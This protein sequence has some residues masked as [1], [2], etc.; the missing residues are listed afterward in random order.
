[1]GLN[2]NSMITHRYATKP[3]G[4][5]VQNRTIG[6]L[7]AGILIATQAHF[8]SSGATWFVTSLGDAGPG[9]L[10][11]RV[12]SASDGDWIKFSVIG[13]IQLES[14]IEV[15]HRIGIAGPSAK[16]LTIDGQNFD[17]NLFLVSYDGKVGG[18]P[19]E[20]KTPTFRGM[21]LINAGDH[22]IANGYEFGRV[23]IERC[24]FESN[25][26]A[27]FATTVEIWNSY[28]GGNDYGTFS[29]GDMQMV[30]CTVSGNLKRA[31]SAGADAM[32]LNSTIVNNA[33]NAVVGAGGGVSA[34]AKNLHLYN[35]IIAGN[36]EYDLE[37]NMPE[38]LVSSGNL[39]SSISPMDAED[40]LDPTDTLGL[41]LAQ[42][43]LAPLAFNGGGTKNHRPNPGSPAI[44][45][46]VNGVLPSS[47]QRGYARVVGA[48]VDVGAVEFGSHFNGFKTKLVANS[49]QSPGSSGVFARLQVKHESLEE[50]G[51]TVVWTVDGRTAKVESIEASKGP[52]SIELEFR[53]TLPPGDHV[54]STTLTDGNAHEIDRE[55]V[56]VPRAK[57]LR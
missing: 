39:I 52:G 36:G 11:D 9:T 29:H 50:T 44:N 48:T 30:N 53:Q 27:V 16:L 14:P 42:V 26:R 10:R 41:T 3:W 51:L 12:A 28:V 46:G 18:L 15:D 54:I 22:G 37:L 40:F 32:I 33:V 21:R 49:F 25:N 24:S 55:S 38:T 57:P 19:G 47:D 5:R 2:E 1:M 34:T 45:G 17:G 13:T 4:K 6:N 7:A 56:K 23:R 8:A 20:P 31:V 35:T 43:D